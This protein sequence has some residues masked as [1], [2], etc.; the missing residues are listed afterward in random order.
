MT[1]LSL[2]LA[3]MAS[4]ALAQT[5]A[6]PPTSAPTLDTWLPRPG[7]E[8]TALDKITA[9]ATTL[10]GRVGQTLSFGSLSITVR[11]CLVRGPDQPADQ[12]A[13]LEI[14]DSRDPDHRFRGWVLLSVPG[15]SM[16]EHPVY[17]VHLLAC[18]A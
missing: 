17:D 13:F 16:L 4:S 11:A 18:R 15:V 14:A 5:P 1:R 9:R 10:P 8:L 12:A 3:L 2:L 6:P 7:V